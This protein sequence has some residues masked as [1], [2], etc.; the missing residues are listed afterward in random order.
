MSKNSEMDQ[1]LVV[2]GIGASAGGLD[3]LKKIF[4]LLAPHPDV[5]YIVA[6]HLS[7]AHHSHLAEIIGTTSKMPIA[8]AKHREKIVGGHIYVAP[9]NCNIETLKGKIIL[10]EPDDGPGPKPSATMLLSSLAAEYKDRA[11]AIILSGTGSDGAQ[12]IRNIRLNGGISMAQSPD[13]AQYNGM[14][15]AAID[16]RCVDMVLPVEKIVSTLEQV[17]SKPDQIAQEMETVS[18]RDGSHLERIAAAVRTNTEIDIALYKETTLKRRIQRRMAIRNIT[19]VPEYE[20]LIRKDEE[21]SL[22]LAN[23]VLISVTSFFRNQEVFDEV[24]H[25]LKSL[26][27]HHE[28]GDTIR[29]WVPACA[30]GEEAY[31]I[32]ILYHELIANESN[33]PTLVIFASDMDENAIDVARLGIYGLDSLANMPAD[34]VDKYFAKKGNTLQVKKRIRQQVVFSIQNIAE[35]PPFSRMDLVSCRNLLIYL[36]P[37][38]QK[39][40][41]ELLHY[42]LLD[43]GYLVLGASESAD[44]FS[45]LFTTHSKSL[46]IYRKSSNAMPYKTTFADDRTNPRLNQFQTRSTEEREQRRYTLQELANQAICDENQIVWAVVDEHDV[47]KCLSRDAGPVFS[48]PNGPTNL[49]VYNMVPEALQPE[50]RGLLYRARKDDIAVT[51]APNKVE[52]DGEERVFRVSILPI[53]DRH[54]KLWVVALVEDPDYES[55]ETSAAGDDGSSQQYIRDLEHRLTFLQQDLQSATEELETSNEELQSQS[56]EL[57]S[58]NE[59]LQSMNEQLLTSNEELQSSNEELLTM[60]DEIRIKSDQLE[61]AA[62]S[63]HTLIETSEHPILFCNALHRITAANKKAE[64]VAEYDTSLLGLPVQN[65]AWKFEAKN[66]IQAVRNVC[67][68]GGSST[69]EVAPEDKLWQVEL[70]ACTYDEQQIEGAML[71]FLPQ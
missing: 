63:L 33:F 6:Q 51:G 21:E 52:I 45:D 47:V 59:E 36:K 25:I 56:E 64:L 55:I 9:P 29:I 69:I 54:E 16:T 18:S 8:E 34:W 49:R 5:A 43:G 24:N 53:T 19:H 60:N 10:S 44:L 70:T 71:R 4:K 62:N 68:N 15:K 31:S 23:S 40:V 57:Q 50:I 30:T 14:P 65:I 61:H 35:D 26:I 32:A 20:K 11:I 46:R 27:S 38:V 12:G 28:R 48:L 22:A 37:K 58:S 41:F 67:S 17:L 42:S 1:N 13:E 39:Q 66:F 7:P 2:C 3:P